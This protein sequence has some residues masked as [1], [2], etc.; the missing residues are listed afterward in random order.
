MRKKIL[1]KIFIGFLVFSMSLS[2]ILTAKS[3]VPQATTFTETISCSSETV[4][5]DEQWQWFKVVV[6]LGVTAFVNVSYEGDLDID[7]RLYWKRNNFPEF[8][9]FD[10]T[11]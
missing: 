7:I 3:Q 6:E 1:P 9:G 5:S 10:L 2:F 8:N 11:H 4:V